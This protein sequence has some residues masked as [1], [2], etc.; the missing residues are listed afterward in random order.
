MY[1]FTSI[2]KRMFCE[3]CGLYVNDIFKSI[4]NKNEYFDYITISCDDK[5]V[6]LCSMGCLYDFIQNTNNNNYKNI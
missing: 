2:K 3:I 1:I 4:E 5:K 6:I